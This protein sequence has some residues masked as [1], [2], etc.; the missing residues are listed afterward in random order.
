[1]RQGCI[2]NYENMMAFL[3][4]ITYEK[5]VL[6]RRLETTGVRVFDTES[7]EKRSNLKKRIKEIDTTLKYYDK[8]T[9]KLTTFDSE[10]LLSFFSVFLSR[11]TGEEYRACEGIRKVYNGK[12][13]SVFY[14]DLVYPVKDLYKFE[15][16]GY[17]LNEKL[18][19][20][21]FEENTT[22][23]YIDLSSDKEYTL[24]GIDG[25]TEEFKMFSELESVCRK[26][27]DMKLSFPNI[28][29]ALCLNR[30]LSTLKTNLSQENSVVQNRFVYR[31]MRLD[32]K[33]KNFNDVRNYLI[34]VDKRMCVLKEEYKNIKI[35]FYT[36]NRGDLKRRKEEIKKELDYWTKM[37]CY[38]DSLVRNATRFQRTDLGEFFR[39]YFSLM[40]GKGY[41]VYSFK[42]ISEG[43]SLYDAVL[44]LSDDD[45][46]KVGKNILT[47][48]AIHAS[49]LLKRCKDTA[50]CLSADT[51]F[52]FD[53]ARG[54]SQFAA[55][56]D[57]IKLAIRMVDMKL[58]EPTLTDKEILKAL[59]E[60]NRL[61]QNSSVRFACK[62]AESVSKEMLEETLQNIRR[63]L[64]E[65]PSPLEMDETLF[66]VPGKEDLSETKRLSK[67]MMDMYT[68]RGK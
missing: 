59:I 11:E 33:V 6:K 60:E 22:S 56:P 2:K 49:N 14:Y 25:L 30:V 48:G 35:H 20:F 46:E 39:E 31:P 68:R 9:R 38:Y 67:S 13:W 15:I 32:A 4:G 28:S 1:M 7:R 51:Y 61:Q 26:I 53:N 21:G 63:V 3:D 55:F 62:K 64:H 37:N 57:I 45:A 52:L 10:L 54:K 50:I 36:L 18:P 27:I 29:D 42:D 40:Y 8:L 12:S 24:M 65:Q 44:V 5:S 43:C 58:S 66:F 41:G 16:E 47:T 19:C 34:A 17:D 23:R